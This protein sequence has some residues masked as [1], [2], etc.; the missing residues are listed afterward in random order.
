[1]VDENCI[2]PSLVSD[3]QTVKFQRLKAKHYINFPEKNGQRNFPK[4]R[5]SPKNI[6]RAH[7]ATQM[8]STGNEGKDKHDSYL[9]RLLCIFES[10]TPPGDKVKKPLPFISK[11]V[12]VSL[13]VVP[14]VMLAGNQ[15]FT[16][17]VQLLT[18]WLSCPHFLL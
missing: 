6:F 18:T 4:K 1:V 11:T 5:S 14:G 7:N 13:D 16:D 10:C 2:A 17:L 15:L 9:M 8:S 12:D 3:H